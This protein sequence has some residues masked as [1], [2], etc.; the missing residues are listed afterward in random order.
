MIVLLITGA[1]DISTFNIPATNVTGIEQRLFQYLW[2]IEYAIDHYNKVTHIIFCENT[3]YNYDYSVLKEKASRKGKFFETL[4][5]KGD[6]DIIQQKGKGYGEGEIIKYAIENSKYLRTCQSFY[7]LTGRLLVANMDRIISGTLSVNAFDFHPGAI[8][9]RKRGHV[10]TLFYKTDKNLFQIY[11]NDAYREVDEAKFRYLEH[12]FYQRL[13][14][15]NLKSFRI[16][17]DISGQ[18]GTTG[19]EY[20][21]PYHMQLAEKFFYAIGIHNLQKNPM[22]KFLFYL[23]IGMLFIWRRFKGISS[24]DR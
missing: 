24:R 18:S 13:K 21:R 7:K 19:K 3:D 10:E 17:P 15:L 20:S 12:I 1:I 6:Y 4:P 22:E 16:F 2:S 14:G 23:L 8:Y 5:F 11:L 9:N